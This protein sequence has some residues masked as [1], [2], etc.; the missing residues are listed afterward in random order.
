MYLSTTILL[1]GHMMNYYI[2]GKIYAPNAATFFNIV[3][4]FLS[5]PISDN[6]VLLYSMYCLGLP[7]FNC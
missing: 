3:S 4:T 1:G 7:N 5:V 2:V 6:N